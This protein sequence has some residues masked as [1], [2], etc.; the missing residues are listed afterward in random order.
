M[1]ELLETLQSIDAAVKGRPF[2]EEETES[3][4]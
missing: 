1:E 2:A 3:A 4:D